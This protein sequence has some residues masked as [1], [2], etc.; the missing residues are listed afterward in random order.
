MRRATSEELRRWHEAKRWEE[1]QEA[2][3]RALEE[4]VRKEDEAQ[5]QGAPPAKTKAERKAKTKAKADHRGR[6][7]DYSQSERDKTVKEWLS[8]GSNDLRTLP[9]FLIDLF[10]SNPK[11]DDSIDPKPH[12]I[13]SCSRFYNWRTDYLKRNPKARQRKRE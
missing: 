8:K 5:R 3:L 12:P 13:V 11:W 4:R 6:K 9:V 1:Q 7:S 10:G 2:K